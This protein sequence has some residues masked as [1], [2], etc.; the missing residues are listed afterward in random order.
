MI[1]GLFRGSLTDFQLRDQRDIMERPFF[2]LAKTPRFTPIE[3]IGADGVSF[4]KVEPGPSG[5]PTIWD[6]DILIWAASQLTNYKNNKVNH[7]PRTLRFVP[8][9]LLISIHRDTGGVN[10]ERLRKSLTR[11]KTATVTTNVRNLK[12]TKKHQFNW[13]E[14]WKDEINNQTALSQGME[15]TLSEWFYEGVLMEGSVLTINPLYFS[16]KG[17]RERW[18]YKVCRK[19]AGPNGFSINFSTLFEK[20]GAEGEF[21]RF[22]YEILKIVQQNNLP[23]LKLSVENREGPDPL[24][25]FKMRE[26]TKSAQ[27]TQKQSQPVDPAT[28]SLIAS[29]FPG[30]DPTSLQPAFDA[31]LQTQKKPQNYSSAFFDYCRDYH[32][33]NNP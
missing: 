9:E 4:V 14:S 13:I 7:I 20:S 3:Y 12:T 10:Y 22:K 1:D 21:R 32:D 23:D 8:H 33:K 6:A 29:K 19:H 31:W 17:G 16:L 5:L 15:I 2:S 11:L 27:T 26:K 18:L 25:H 24:L 30:I 28:L